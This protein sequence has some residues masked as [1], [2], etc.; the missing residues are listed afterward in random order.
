MNRADK[1]L[2]EILERDWVHYVSKCES[3]DEIPWQGEGLM[4]KMQIYQGDLPT[5]GT[6]KPDMMPSTIDKYRKI[7]ITEAERFAARMAFRVPANLQKHIMVEPIIR[8]REKITQETIAALC[9]CT[10]DQYKKG[11][12]KAKLFWI[13]HARM[14]MG[15][16]KS[17]ATA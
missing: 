7:P 14:N 13:Y 10:L 11:R 8:R 12:A 9:S 2:F 1:E 6:Y 3:R 16:V 4:A 5:S 17:L 15:K